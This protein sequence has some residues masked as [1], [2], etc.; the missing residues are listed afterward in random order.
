MLFEISLIMVW[1]GSEWVGCFARFLF[2]GWFGLGVGF[3]VFAFVHALWFGDFF[4]FLY[5]W[6]SCSFILVLLFDSGFDVVVEFIYGFDVLVFNFFISLKLINYFFNLDADVVFFNVKIDF[7]IIILMCHQPR[8]L[9][10][11]VE[12]Q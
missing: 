5:V 2:F 4:F 1:F 3:P 11:L 12:W 10:L 7:L 8:Q 6:C 9:F